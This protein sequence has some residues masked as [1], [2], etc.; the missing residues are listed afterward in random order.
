MSDNAEGGIAATQAKAAGAQG[1]QEHHRSTVKNLDDRVGVY[2]WAFGVIL[3]CAV[4]IVSESS[5]IRYAA[6]AL[7]LC[8]VALFAVMR[9]RR[10]QKLNEQRMRQAQEYED[11]RIKKS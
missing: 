8:A 4:W 2:F 9:V 5:L 1:L 6:L 7:G 3:L 10:I 11:I